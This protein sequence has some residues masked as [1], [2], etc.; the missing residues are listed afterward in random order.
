MP[1]WRSYSWVQKGPVP[2]CWL[3]IALPPG[4]SQWSCSTL[5]IFDMQKT[6]EN[7]VNKDELWWYMAGNQK[8]DSI[9]DV[10]TSSCIRPEK[11]YPSTKT[12]HWTTKHD[13]Y[14]IKNLVLQSDLF[15]HQFEVNPNSGPLN[16]LKRVTSDVFRPWISVLP[17]WWW[18]GTHECRSTTCDA[19]QWV[20]S[21]PCQT[22]S[23]ITPPKN[24]LSLCIYIYISSQS[25]QSIQISQITFRKQCPLRPSGLGLKMISDPALEPWVPC[26][27]CGTC[28]F[29]L[30]KY[31]ISFCWCC[32]SDPKWP[33]STARNLPD[34]PLGIWGDPKSEFKTRAVVHHTNLQTQLHFMTSVMQN[35]QSNI[36]QGYL[37]NGPIRAF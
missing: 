11:C 2:S 3:R 13:M 26:S 31:C 8:Q 27:C 21:L 14:T 6:W 37:L 24:P 34:G 36:C 20:D 29:K 15:D 22:S 30:F 16:H 19:Q 28:R 23:N 12:K 1:A 25:T 33:D 18:W 4:S 17:A 5:A 32:T 9:I 7:E 35:S 10:R